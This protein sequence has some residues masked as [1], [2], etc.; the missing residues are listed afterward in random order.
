M[1]LRLDAS[2][3]GAVSELHD[4][5]QAERSAGRKHPAC[6]RTCVVAVVQ[7]ITQNATQLQL[8][9][10]PPSAT[11]VHEGCARCCDLTGACTIVLPVP[12]H[13]RLPVQ[14]TCELFAAENGERG[15]RDVVE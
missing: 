7:Q 10:D 15:R 12:S 9:E 14:I 11:Q 13:T 1:N 5:R 4:C 8:R 2:R 3:S 6:I